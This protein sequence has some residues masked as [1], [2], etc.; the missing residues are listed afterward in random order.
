MNYKTEKLRLLISFTIRL[1]RDVQQKLNDG[2]ISVIEIITLLPYLKDIKELCSTIDLVK[3]DLK[4]L[5]PEELKNLYDWLES[6]HGINHKRAQFVID[7]FFTFVTS[8]KNFVIDITPS[9][10][11]GVI[12][13]AEDLT[14]K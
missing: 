14:K 8:I 6:K 5:S 3:A 13:P 1:V 2:K 10:D 9:S 11:E 12:I 7:S 4:S